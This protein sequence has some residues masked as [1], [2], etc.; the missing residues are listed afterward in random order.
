MTAEIINAAFQLVCNM[1]NDIENAR[2]LANGVGI[3]GCDALHDDQD[4]G[5][6]FIRLARL[7][8]DHC[9]DIEERRGELFQLLHPNRDHFETVG[10]PSAEPP[11]P[12][13]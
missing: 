11:D 12:A 5:A 7:I 10:W 4:L 2:V 6:V 3:L 9:K 13:A 8:A 1:E